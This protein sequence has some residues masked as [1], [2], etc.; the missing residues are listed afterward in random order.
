[1]EMYTS[2]SAIWSPVGFLL[3][4]FFSSYLDDLSYLLYSACLFCS[5]YSQSLIFKYCFNIHHFVRLKVLF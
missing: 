3:F 1:M 5:C 4:F 2:F